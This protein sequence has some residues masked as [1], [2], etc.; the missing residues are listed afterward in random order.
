VSVIKGG[1]DSVNIRG[2]VGHPGGAVLLVLEYDAGRELRRDLGSE[3]VEKWV[4]P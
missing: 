1:F 2:A 4:S 3:R